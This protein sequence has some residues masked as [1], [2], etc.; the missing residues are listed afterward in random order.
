M[1]RAASEAEANGTRAKRGH[2]C[3]A[4]ELAVKT[5]R[6][7]HNADLAEQRISGKEDFA[8][9][10]YT[11]GKEIADLVLDC[12]HKLAALI[13]VMILT[14]KSDAIGLQEFMLFHACGGDTVSGSGCLIGDLGLDRT[15]KLADYCAL[16]SH[17]L[18]ENADEVFL[19]DNIAL[20]DL[21]YPT[22]ELTTPTHGAS[23]SKQVDGKVGSMGAK[24]A[25][26]PSSTTLCS[27]PFRP[28]SLS[29]ITAS[30]MTQSPWVTFN[31]QH[32]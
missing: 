29:P 19:L 1:A 8:R 17:Q 27:E 31:L 6:D 25:A 7:K 23:R 26:H 32:G 22:F 18:V 21:C 3:P 24:T 20:Y 12:I 5:L 9:G 16:S 30:L 15:R 14:G 4:Q 28:T 10:R 2:S 13:F 11:I